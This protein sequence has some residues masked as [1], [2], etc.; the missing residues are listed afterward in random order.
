MGNHTAATSSAHKTCQNLSKVK[1]E[2]KNI[3]G[4]G[5]D[6]GPSIVRDCQREEI[7]SREVNAPKE[8]AEQTGASAEGL[9]NEEIGASV[10]IVFKSNDNADM[11][12]RRSTRKKGVRRGRRASNIAMSTDKPSNE[13]SLM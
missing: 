5:G 3:K 6:H 9:L 2:N 1:K 8:I 11:E 13:E 12:E 4:A 7:S 10:W